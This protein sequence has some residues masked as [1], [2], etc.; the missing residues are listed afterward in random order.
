MTLAAINIAVTPIICN[1]VLGDLITRPSHWRYLEA[2]GRV[3]SW[4]DKSLRD[5]YSSKTCQWGRLPC[6]GSLEEDRTGCVPNMAMISIEDVNL[7]ISLKEQMHYLNQPVNQN[8]AHTR[9][10]CCPRKVQTRVNTQTTNTMLGQYDW[11][12]HP[13]RKSFLMTLPASNWRR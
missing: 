3:Q 13:F 2:W 10:N 9:C 1:F 5:A 11:L 7:K 12:T 4:C 6:R 8:C